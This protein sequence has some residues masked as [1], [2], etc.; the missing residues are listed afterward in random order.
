MSADEIRHDKTKKIIYYKDA[1]LKIYDKK[2]FYFPRFFHP[3][4]TVKRQTGFLIPRL[5]ENSTTGL[6]LKLPYF[7]AIA[8]NKDITLSPRFFNDDKFLLQSEF[9]QKNKKSD[10][11]ADLSQFISSDK[12]QKDIYFIILKRIMKVIILMKLN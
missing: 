8:E 2:I 7:L 3:D 1:S 10:H 12:I 4:P 5:Q 9:R 6:S 11:I